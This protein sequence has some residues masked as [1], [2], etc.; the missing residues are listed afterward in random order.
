MDDK[1]RATVGLEPEDFDTYLWRR[2]GIRLHESG[3]FNGPKNYTAYDLF[4]AF[5]AGVKWTC[6]LE[7]LLDEIAKMGCLYKG[8][9]KDCPACYVATVRASWKAPKG[10]QDGAR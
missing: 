7:D 6:R 10:G 4:A 5:C 1:E 2:H 8:N 3:G 9:L